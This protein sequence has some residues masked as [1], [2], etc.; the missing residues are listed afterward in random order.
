MVM[1]FKNYMHTSE[2]FFTSQ[3]LLRKPIIIVKI[4]SKLEE[5]SV[6]TSHLI[7]EETLLRVKA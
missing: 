3:A 5:I 2:S 4:Y 6:L 7:H 1:L